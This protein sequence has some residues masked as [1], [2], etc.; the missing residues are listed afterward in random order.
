[1]LNADR[2]VFD[3]GIGVYGHVV[4]FRQLKNLSG[5]FFAV[6]EAA[7]DAFAAEH[8]VVNDGH[9]RHKLEV[10]MDHTDAEIDGVAWGVH[11][12]RAA[13]DLNLALGGLVKPIDDVHESRLASAV[14]A[15]Q[16][17]DFALVQSEVYVFVG[18][19]SGE[20]LG[21]PEDFEF[22]WGGVGLIGPGGL[23]SGHAL[24]SVS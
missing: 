3:D 7:V 22:G 19:D 8:D 1:M 10:L 13:V 20:E 6:Q 24:P 15:Q 9:D 5:D 12:D 2:Q 14:L 23:G 18:D 4:T 17:E 11:F 21:D 16:G